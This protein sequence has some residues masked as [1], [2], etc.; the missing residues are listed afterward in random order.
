MH[1]SRVRLYSF[2]LFCRRADPDPGTSRTTVPLF[3]FSSPNVRFFHVDQEIMVV[4]YVK[5]L[6]LERLFRIV[7]L[8]VE[9]S[10]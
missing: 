10:E 6:R 3:L 8:K 5:K 1:D 9:V 2:I 7:N 4:V